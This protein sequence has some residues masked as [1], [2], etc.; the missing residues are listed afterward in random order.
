VIL[1]T[2]AVMRNIVVNCGTLM[3]LESAKLRDFAARYTAAWCSQ[4]AANVAAG[5]SSDG[6]LTM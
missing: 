4:D 2:G 1:H 5:Y 3:M 6:S